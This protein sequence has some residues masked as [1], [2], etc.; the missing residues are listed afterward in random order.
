MTC[1]KCGKE[2]VPEALFCAFCGQPAPTVEPEDDRVLTRPKTGRVIGGVAAGMS[3]AFGIPVVWLR[4]MWVVLSI[5]T[6]GLV[7]IFYLVL[8]FAIPEENGQE[9]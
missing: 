9:E 1:T 4:V 7:A 3:E 6:I 2:L 5:A 8:C